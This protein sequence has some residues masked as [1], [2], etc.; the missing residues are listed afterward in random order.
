MKR[1]KDRREGE[2]DVRGTAGGRF[3]QLEGSY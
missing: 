1:K 3:N 2:R